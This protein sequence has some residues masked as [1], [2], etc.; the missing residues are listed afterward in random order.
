MN[1]IY[2]ILK[3]LLDWIRETPRDD[4]QDGKAP[5]QLK[6]DLRDR[7]S[8]LPGMSDEGGPGPFR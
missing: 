1:W 3:A 6:N 2:Q 4:I 8:G 5:D 7:I